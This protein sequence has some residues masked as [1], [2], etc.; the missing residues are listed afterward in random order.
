R[1]IK[2][3]SAS[4][5]PCTLNPAPW[6]LH[7]EPCTLQPALLKGLQKLPHLL[8]IIIRHPRLLMLHLAISADDE[9]S[10]NGSHLKEFGK[11]TCGLI[12]RKCEA[13]V[14]NVTGDVLV[15]SIFIK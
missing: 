2:S 14:R 11:R 15:L 13:F 9:R 8:R 5:L 6:T 4:G 3:Y 10:R 1:C 12:D 7:P